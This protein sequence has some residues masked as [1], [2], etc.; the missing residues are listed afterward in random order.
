MYKIAHLTSVHQRYDARIFFKECLSLANNG[1]VVNLIVADGK[2]SETKDR[3]SILDVGAST[4]RM[5]RILNS[6]G[7]VYKK[8]LELDADLY[9]F[10]DP[11][12]IPVGLKLKKLGYRV[13]FDIHENT[14]MQI[15]IKEWIPFYI[16]RLASRIYNIFEVFACRKFDALIVPQVSMQKKFCQFSRCELVANFPNGLIGSCER[17]RHN[18]HNLFYAGG[19]SKAR[20]LHN[21]LDL[22]VALNE[23]DSEYRLKL[24]GPISKVD[25]IDMQAHKGWHS[26]DYLG[27]LNKDQVYSEY[28]KNSI[29]LIL[30][31][32]AGQYHMSYALKL[33]EYMQCGM[34]VIMPN[35]G[36][37]TEFN[38]KFR[39]GYNVDV[40]SPA[41]TA[42]LIFSLNEER[43]ASFA[44]HN[45]AVSKLHFL[46]A[47]QEK[48]LLS[49]YGELLNDKKV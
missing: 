32:N 30:F 9:H 2:G 20:G 38:K 23:L 36:E 40:T 27:V 42:V 39:V 13:V 26:V 19:L 5:D 29:G 34:T 6:S 22:I 15:L 44:N 18:K 24:A 11:E 16:R 10:H 31:N 33:F 8:A 7:R 47:T 28:R 49:L 25:M 12:L 46:W 35:F 41:Q 37:W 3:I 48:T 1:Y 4:G 45:H 17:K 43:L 21:M 14:D